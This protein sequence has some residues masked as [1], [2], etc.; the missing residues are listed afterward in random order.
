MKPVK[1]VIAVRHDLGM[2]KG[3]S[4]AQGSH[5]SWAVFKKHSSLTDDRLVLEMWPEAVEWFRTG[6]TKI[7]VRVD[8]EDE[9]IALAKRAAADNIPWA[10]VVDAGRTEFHGVPTTTA[11]AIGPHDSEEI[12]KLTTS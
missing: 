8:S 11:I 6:T 4:I 9:L 12:D 10:T 7:C 3:K 1:Q 2:R 5:A